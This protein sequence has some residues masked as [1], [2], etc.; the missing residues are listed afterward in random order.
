MHGYGA[1]MMIGP[2][3]TNPV[4][5]EFSLGPF[6]EEEDP[7]FAAALC[8]ATATFTVGYRPV[9]SANPQQKH[10]RALSS[11]HYEPVCSVVTACGHTGC[12][13]EGDHHVPGDQRGRRSPR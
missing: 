2:S 5:H 9:L 12:L 1:E 8:A 13:T 10:G 7:L 4:D 6:L 3:G 11:W